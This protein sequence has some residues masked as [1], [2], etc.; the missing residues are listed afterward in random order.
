MWVL[1]FS[2]VDVPQMIHTQTP[3]ILNF[4][5]FLESGFNRFD[6]LHFVRHFAGGK[7]L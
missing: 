4:G 6:F 5:Y 7:R 2:Y 3:Y 1:T